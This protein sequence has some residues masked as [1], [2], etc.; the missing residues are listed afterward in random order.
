MRQWSSREFRISEIAVKRWTEW[1]SDAWIEESADE[2]V[3][4]PSSAK[5]TGGRVVTP[6]STPPAGEARRA[7]EAEPRMGDERTLY[8]VREKGGFPELEI[9]AK[10]VGSFPALTRSPDMAEC[11]YNSRTA[12]CSSAPAISDPEPPGYPRINWA[13]S[14]RSRAALDV[15][16][17]GGREP[18]APRIDEGSSVGTVMGEPSTRLRRCRSP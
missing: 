14:R 18:V 12:N 8:I 13:A 15:G 10:E 3:V 9:A 2:N 11:G 5:F 16:R 1:L 7:Q 6:D 4:A 17:N